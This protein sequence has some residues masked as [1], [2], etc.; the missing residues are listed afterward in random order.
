MRSQQDAG[1]RLVANGLRFLPNYG[2]LA[3]AATLLSALARPLDVL[4]C[5]CVGLSALCANAPLFDAAWPLLH[6]WAV[7]DVAGTPLRVSGVAIK[8]TGHNV[9]DEQKLWGVHKQGAFS[10]TRAHIGAR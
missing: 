9:C 10:H 1:A 8:L 3:A 2:A 4:F 7:F 5:A 6:R